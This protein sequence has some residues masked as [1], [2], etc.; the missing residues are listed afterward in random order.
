[1]QKRTAVATAVGGF[2][3]GWRGSVAENVKR[4]EVVTVLSSCGLLGAHEG[5]SQESWRGL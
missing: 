5:Q 1:M 3:Q 2:R 4:G